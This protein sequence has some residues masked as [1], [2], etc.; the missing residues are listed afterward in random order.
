M[1]IKI[2]RRMANNQITR[3]LPEIKCDLIEKS[4]NLYRIPD[5][6]LRETVLR[7]Y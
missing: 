1:E 3:Y 5:P 6:L 4:N 7:E 2:R